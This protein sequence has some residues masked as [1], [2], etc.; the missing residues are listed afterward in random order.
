MRDFTLTPKPSTFSERSLFKVVLQYVS[1]RFLFRTAILLVLAGGGACHPL[2]HAVEI[3]HIAEPYGVAHLRHAPVALRKHTASHLHAVS[4]EIFHESLSR[5]LP[6]K[7]AESRLVHPHKAG[8]IVD[9][10]MPSVI[11]ND[12][13]TYSV[14]TPLR[15][16]RTR[17]A[18]TPV[19]YETLIFSINNNWFFIVFEYFRN[20]KKQ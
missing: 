13:C 11:A 4:V 3:R 16:A 12:V 18:E 8:D 17:V 1:S 2:E 14:H 5:H 9:S 19:P 10:D 15:R 7:H 20:V 6:E